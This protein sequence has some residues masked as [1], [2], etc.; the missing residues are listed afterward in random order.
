MSILCVNVRRARLAPSARLNSAATVAN[1]LTSG[2]GVRSAVDR[3]DQD[4][5]PTQFNCYVVLKLQNV[6]SSTDTCGGLQPGWEQDFLFET[7]SLD[8]GLLVE[9]WNKGLLWDKLLGCLWIPLS[10]VR[11]SSPSDSPER[12]QGNWYVLNAEVVRDQR[13]QVLGTQLN[14]QHMLLIDC[15]FEPA[16]EYTSLD[17][18]DRFADTSTSAAVASTARLQSRTYAGSPLASAR[19]AADHQQRYGWASGT[20]TAIDPLTVSSAYALGQSIDEDEFEDERLALSTVPAAAVATG[21]VSVSPGASRPYPTSY[22]PVYGRSTYSSPWR[23]YGTGLEMPTGS[24]NRS[25]LR[26][27]LTAQ[28]RLNE[29]PLTSGALLDSTYYHHPSRPQVPDTRGRPHHP[30]EPISRTALLSN[31]DRHAVST[32]LSRSP[33]RHPPNSSSGQ[34]TYQ[35]SAYDTTAHHGYVQRAELPDAI[36]IKP[37]SADQFV[38]KDRP[39]VHSFE[40]QRLTSLVAPTSVSGQSIGESSGVGSSLHAQTLH[41]RTSVSSSSAAQPLLAVHQV[42]SKAAG[43]VSPAHHS[44]LHSHPLHHQPE[45]APPPPSSSHHT[46]QPVGVTLSGG[47][48][49]PPTPRHGVG[50]AS[51]R[52]LPQLDLSAVGRDDPDSALLSA[53]PIKPIRTHRKLPQ[54]NH[55]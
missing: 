21:Y 10:E 36:A 45:A 55:R 2:G 28:Q 8:T 27:Q 34:P 33:V 19:Q 3:S 40:T 42:P 25:P 14:T 12:N 13:N 31:T 17:Q 43:S 39:Y 38:P 16:Y 4:S 53:Q 24:L 30:H 1:L 49:L 48:S 6:R 54:I 32:H 26:T 23:S 47:S 5:D 46:H 20:A 52:R 29:Y 50:K 35:A 37:S 51:G 22:E 11:Y 41:H 7:N 18:L 15:H 9:L 44:S